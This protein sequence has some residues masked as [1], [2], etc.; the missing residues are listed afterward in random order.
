MFLSPLFFWAGGSLVISLAGLFLSS[1][2][3][4]IDLEKNGDLIV[5]MLT[6]LG[7]LVSV[8]LGLLVSSADDQ[9][10]R[11]EDCVNSES[12]SINEI[13]RLSR[14]LPK[15]VSYYVQDRC[16]AYSDD[17]INDE[18]PLMKDGKFSSLVT[19]D[20]TEL[21]DAIVEFHP[22]NDGEAA[23]QGALLSV[24]SDVGQN[25]GLRVV[26]SRSNWVW[27]LLPLIITCAVVVL[28]CSYL[29][30]GKG[31]ALLHA[32]LVGLV[33]ITLGINIGVI[34]L[35]TRPFSSE[36]AIQPEG[37]QLRGK[38]MQEYRHSRPALV[39]SLPVKATP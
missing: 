37:F 39:P 28:A 12:T 35:M 21:S 6:I 22:S 8:L 24:A 17:V 18:W 34:F 5:A 30:V 29:Y 20:F 23:I 32:I 38:I 3:F 4:K 10:R 36:W 11:L 1:K 33:A 7:T 13:F 19:K 27:R 31:S 2:L 16:I 26:A 25:R 15:Q 9:Y 14:G